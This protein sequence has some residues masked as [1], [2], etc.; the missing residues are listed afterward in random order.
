MSIYDVE[1]EILKNISS[2]EFREFG[3]IIG[4]EEDKMESVNVIPEFTSYP[5]IVPF[6]KNEKGRFSMG[7]LLLNEKPKGGL[8]V[9]TESHEGSYE[10]FFPLAGKQIIFV[11]APP[12]PT[13][14]VEKTRAF[15]IG[16][17]EGIMLNK[18]V[19]HH[20]PIPVSGKTPCL[21]P[22]FG[23]LIE[24]EGKLV[25]RKTN[26]Y[27]ERNIG[28]HGKKIGEYKIRIIL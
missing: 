10:F 20:P 25:D 17:D 3:Y 11:L 1:L 22:R 24:K 26:Y 7:L 9:W 28:Y 4:R 23:D 2:E 6:L 15:L 18:K 13:P 27:G 8:V 19:W 21:L 5:D 14:E 12:G 16:P